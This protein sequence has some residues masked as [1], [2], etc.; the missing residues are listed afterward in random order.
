[1]GRPSASLLEPAANIAATAVKAA[2]VYRRHYHCS[3]RGSAAAAP[4]DG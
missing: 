3:P 4:A 2:V 1:M